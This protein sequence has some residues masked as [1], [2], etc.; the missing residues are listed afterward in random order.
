MPGAAFERLQSSLAV[1]LI[2]Q[3]VIRVVRVMSF[4]Y[5]ITI[6]IEY[7]WIQINK[8]VKN[9]RKKITESIISY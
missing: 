2:S 4:Y 7:D 1:L 6:F 3:C 8:N 5:V 9:R